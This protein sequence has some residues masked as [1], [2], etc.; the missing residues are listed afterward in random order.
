MCETLP[1]KLTLLP[2]GHGDYYGLA[3]AR[4]SLQVAQVNA[5][6]YYG[7]DLLTSRAHDLLNGPVDRVSRYH[8]LPGQH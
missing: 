6:C 5:V 3:N 2:I 4:A 1:F 8:L 7:N